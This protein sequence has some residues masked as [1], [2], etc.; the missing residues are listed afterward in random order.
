MAL[1][2]KFFL[3]V[4]AVCWGST[5][6]WAQ[7]ELHVWIEALETLYSLAPKPDPELKIQS[8]L[9]H[10]GIFDHRF[11]IYPNRWGR[12]RRIQPKI[13]LVLS[14]FS[15][16]GTTQTSKDLRHDGVLYVV[17]E[18]AITS[19]PILSYKDGFSPQLV[20]N[21]FEVSLPNQNK[22]FMKMVG[23][24]ISNTHV[25]I[26]TSDDPEVYR[27]KPPERAYPRR[28]SFEIDISKIIDFISDY[29]E[30]GD[31]P[32]FKMISETTATS[33]ARSLDNSFGEIVLNELI[34]SLQNV[35]RAFEDAYGFNFSYEH[36]LAAAG[37]HN[38]NSESDLIKRK[39]HSIAKSL[40][41]PKI[42]TIIDEENKKLGAR[43]KELDHIQR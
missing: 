42:S 28:S 24:S 32:D 29:F 10:L 38:A 11:A 27:S 14:D 43:L 9:S 17:T 22:F 5:L 3:C 4:V 23:C 33:I 35:T 8:P 19:H 30:Y 20:D 31:L 40:D 34:L 25:C 1:L 7:Q 12:I 2:C 18:Q 15:G 37:H 16:Y 36:V 39:L 6:L 21:Y 13:Y 41:T 26:E